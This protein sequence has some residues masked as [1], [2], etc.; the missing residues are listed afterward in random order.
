MTSIVGA[1]RISIW[2]GTN[3]VV[4]YS[5][6]I[7]KNHHT[8]RAI[9]LL[10]LL[11][12]LAVCTA[13]ERGLP[14]QRGIGN[15]GRVSDMLYRG[16]RP[17]AIGIKNLKELG[18]KIIINLQTAKETLKEEQVDASN[19]GILYTNIPLRGLGRPKDEDV[20]TILSIIDSA[21]G[22]VFIHCK[23]GCDRTGT[24][25]A[26]YR[27]AHDRW[28]NPLALEEAKKYGMSRFELGMKKFV[29]AFAPSLL[30]KKLPEPTV[31]A[32]LEASAPAKPKLP[33]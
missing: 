21:T 14:A 2:Q 3:Q 19:N 27:I 23:V 16:A 10:A 13:G 8:T 28:P 22:P 9:S 25:V 6:V 26:C 4:E 31:H 29:S 18:I 5:I 32:K 24:I 12:S 20:R 11:L 7:E 15:F 33:L 1:R 17:D 30:A